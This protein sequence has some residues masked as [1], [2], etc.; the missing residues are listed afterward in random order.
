MKYELLLHQF[1]AIEAI[2]KSFCDRNHKD[3]GYGQ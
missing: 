1:E 2:G 3:C